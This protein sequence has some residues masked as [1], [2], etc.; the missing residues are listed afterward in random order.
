MRPV[1]RSGVSKGR[2]ARQFKRNVR[3]T[4]GANVAPPPMRGGFRL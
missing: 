3:R 4:K 2:S 1:K